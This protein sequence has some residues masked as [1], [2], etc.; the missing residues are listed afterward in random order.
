MQ[1]A[2][3]TRARTSGPALD[4][5]LDPVHEIELAQEQHG[6][7]PLDGTPGAAREPGLRRYLRWKVR[8]FLRYRASALIPLALLGRCAH[9]HLDRL[10]A[11]CDLE[12]EIGS[13]HRLERSLEHD[14]RRVLC[15]GG[16]DDV[17]L[18]RTRGLFR[19]RLPRLL[20]LGLL[21]AD[22]RHQRDADPGERQ[23]REQQRETSCER[24]RR[25]HRRLAVGGAL[26]GRGDRARLV[27][28]GL[29][30]AP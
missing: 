21:I 17:D 30:G 2:T 11:P 9:D 23:Q 12:P 1:T 26:G 19:S 7:V 14:Q 4:P 22:A 8:D 13:L 20:E 5:A 16:T 27:F 29:H 28:R 3:R 24:R 18:A 6:V 15:G 25:S 10:D